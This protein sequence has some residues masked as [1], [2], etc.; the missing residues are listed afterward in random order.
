M[1]LYVLPGL[2]LVGFVCN[3]MVRPVAAYHFMTEEELQAEG[4]HAARP[5]G[6]GAA[7]QMIFEKPGT[8]SW[9]EVAFG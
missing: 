1:T 6:S 2:L 8:A 9:V 4:Q 3:L 5:A 7:G